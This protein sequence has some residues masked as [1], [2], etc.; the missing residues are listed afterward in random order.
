MR[1]TV[2]IVALAA[3]AAMLGSLAP[4]SDAAEKVSFQSLLEEMIDRDAASRFPSPAYTCKQQSSYDPAT[5]T[6]S[7]PAGWFANNDWSYFR[8]FEK[9]D[10]REESVMLDAAGPGCV[11]RI[12]ATAFNPRGTI[13]VYIDDAAKPAIEERVDRLIGGDALVGKPLSAVQARGMNLYLPI[14]YAKH[15]V[16]TYDRPYFWKKGQ[17]KQENQLYYQ[18]NYRTYEP[19]TQV[20]SYSREAFDKAKETLAKVQK[21]LLDPAGAAPETGV[22]QSAKTVTLGPKATTVTK[23]SGSGAIRKLSVKLEAKDLMAATRSTVIEIEFDGVRT[24]WAPV[25]DFFGSGVGVHPFQTWWRSIAKDGTMT[26][27]WVMPYK[28]S[29]TIRLTN[30]GSQDVQATVGA[31]AGGYQWDDRTM[32]FHANWRHEFPLDAAKKI[33]WNY[34]EAS[35][36]GVYMGDTLAIV[37]PVTAWWGEGDEKV[38][39]DGEKFPS[40]IGTGT[41]DYYGY[42]WCT[43]EFFSDPFHA[44]PWAEG[45]GNKGHATNTRERLLDGIPFT[46]SLKFD[47]EVWHWA[48]VKMSYAVTTFWYGLPGAKGN[49]GPAPDMARDLIPEGPKPMKVAGAIEGEGLKILEKSGGEI[50]VQEAPEHKWSDDKQVWWR[51]GKPGDKL[52]LALPVTKEG[53]YKLEACMTKAIDYAVA[54]ISLDGKVINDKIDLFN[55]GVVTTK[56]SLGEFELGAG[57]HKLT[58]EILGSNPKAVRR[59]M[60]GI[61]YLKLTPVK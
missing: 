11:V 48:P 22:A 58:I 44:Q 39:V 33:D 52:V 13:R 14:P 40:H 43:P 28:Q 23:M 12:W 60:F 36:K 54:R 61:D 31:L 42:A 10:G 56:L 16:V 50:E 27:Y 57:E 51:D 6:A 9:H 20:E 19:G 17:E 18:V 24:V 15:C 47:M 2:K 1:L 3:V 26:C 45:P 32:V 4:R 53:K 29:A 30:L 49:H 35:G 38:Y 37:N 5:K 25:G 7:D 8:R 41:E 55:D 59:H 46:K 21:T 34:L